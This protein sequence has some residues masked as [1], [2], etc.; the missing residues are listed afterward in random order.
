M[1]PPCPIGVGG[2]PYGTGVLE[3]GVVSNHETC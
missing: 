2:A 1:I 3:Q